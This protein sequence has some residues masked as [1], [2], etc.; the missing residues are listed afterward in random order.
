MVLNFHRL[1]QGSGF[2]ERLFQRVAELTVT[3]R[4]VFRV[5]I[6]VIAV[7][8]EVMDKTDR[9]ALRTQ[10]RDPA[11]FDLARHEPRWIQTLQK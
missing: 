5:S 2:R 10:R 1:G 11:F 3:K 9:Q 7:Q 6:M 8:S 4:A